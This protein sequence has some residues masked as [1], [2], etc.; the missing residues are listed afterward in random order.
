MNGERQPVMH[1]SPG[2]TLWTRELHSGSVHGEYT[3]NTAFVT[4]RLCLAELRREP[5]GG[6]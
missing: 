2:N 3:S 1:Y 4:C 6:H 5:D